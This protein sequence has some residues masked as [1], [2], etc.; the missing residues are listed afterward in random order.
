MSLQLSEKK[1]EELADYIIKNNGDLD[2]LHKNI[3]KFYKKI[4]SK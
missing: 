3:D 4:L 2:L 1:K